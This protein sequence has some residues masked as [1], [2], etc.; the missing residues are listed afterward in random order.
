MPKY[1]ILSEIDSPNGPMIF[2]AC[3]L[4]CSNSYYFDI[5]AKQTTF[6]FLKDFSLP[7]MLLF[8]HSFSIITQIIFTLGLELETHLFNLMIEEINL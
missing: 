5:T 8:M 6:L 3:D 7:W 4:L 2:F 1:V